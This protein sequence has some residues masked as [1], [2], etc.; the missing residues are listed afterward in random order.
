VNDGAA[1]TVGVGLRS[2][3]RWRWG[4]KGCRCCRLG[5]GW[6]GRKLVPRRIFKANKLRCFCCCGLIESS[7]IR[8]SVERPGSLT[9]S[10]WGSGKSD[11][12]S[13]LELF[14]HFK[15][16]LSSFVFKD[17]LRFLNWLG[18]CCRQ[19]IGDDEWSSGWGRRR[20]RRGR[21][22]CA[23]RGR[24]RGCRNG[25]LNKHSIAH[26]WSRPDFFGA[27]VL[28]SRELRKVLEG[29]EGL[30][31]FSSLGSRLFFDQFRTSVFVAVSVFRVV[32]N[33]FFDGRRSCESGSSP[34]RV[35]WFRSQWSDRTLRN[36]SS[37]GRNRIFLRLFL[38]LLLLLLLRLDTLT[39]DYSSWSL[40]ILVLIVSLTFGLIAEAVVV[41][42]VA[43][44]EG[45]ELRETG[46]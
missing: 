2:H 22:S 18:M 23:C 45:G 19:E 10:W 46:V 38:L 29:S 8:E 34:S 25:R 11:W 44:G 39:W 7:E 30:C 14:F 1:E 26:G 40:I 42:A 43:D 20:R 24:Q 3:R 33:D 9:W 16:F 12:F 32:V 28:V 37:R 4:W 41:D 6:L 5:W 15:F 35:F 31:S 17:F 27:S 21:G 36:I 13:W